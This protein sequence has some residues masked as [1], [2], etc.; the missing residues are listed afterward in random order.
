MGCAFGWLGIKI[1]P[2]NKPEGKD[3]PKEQ[4]LSCGMCW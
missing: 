2:W 3:R 1:S 4:L